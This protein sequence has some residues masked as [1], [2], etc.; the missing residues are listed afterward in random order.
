MSPDSAGFRQDAGLEL[1]F[2]S[3]ET[4]KKWV[5]LIETD[6]CFNVSAM[7]AFIALPIA[8]GIGLSL[9]TM[10]LV[11]SS[12]PR[13]ARRILGSRIS[14]F[15][16]VSPDRLDAELAR[17]AQGAQRSGFGVAAILLLYLLFRFTPIVADALARAPRAFALAGLAATIGAGVLLAYV[18]VAW[19]RA[20]IL[21]RLDR[22][23]A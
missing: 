3:P 17:A 4:L 15:A 23:F 18:E 10:A 14:R 2:T 22:A 5:F 19:I 21:R 7:D 9:V 8:T 13:W 20:A 12:S 6:S 11:G 16:G 1:P